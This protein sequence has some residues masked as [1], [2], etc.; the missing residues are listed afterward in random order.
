MK[1]GNPELINVSEKLLLSGLLSL[2]ERPA[3]EEKEELSNNITN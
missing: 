2:E 1:T 3:G